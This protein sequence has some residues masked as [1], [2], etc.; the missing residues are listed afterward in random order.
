MYKTQRTSK[1]SIEGEPTSL[2]AA[3]SKAGL[4]YSILLSLPY[5]NPVRFTVI[6]PMHNLYLGTGKHAFEV[7]MEKGLAK[8]EDII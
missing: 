5:F 7:W 4:R 8:F 3:E 2:H 6:D 1:K